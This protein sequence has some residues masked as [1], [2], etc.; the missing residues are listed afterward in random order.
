M[1]TAVDG[2]PVTQFEQLRNA[3]AQK[4]PGDKLELDVF[5]NGRKTSVTVTLGQ[6]PGGRR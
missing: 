2:R 4:K 1:I 5:R 6:A 3:I